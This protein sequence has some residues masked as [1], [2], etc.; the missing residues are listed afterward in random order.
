MKIKVCGM[1]YPANIAEV[2]ALRP[3]L[4]G[5]IFYAPSKRF[6]GEDFDENFL[7]VTLAPSTKRVG[8][9][10]NHPET[11]IEEKARQYSLDILQLHGDEEMAFCASL[12]Q[13]GYTLIKAFQVDS[14]FDFA[15]TKPYKEVAD[16]FLFD[17][18]SDAYGGTG[19]K[20]DWSILSTYDNEVPVV[21]SGGIE[22]DSVEE[23][24]KLSS[25]NIFALDINSR[26]ETEPGLKDPLKIEKFIA[27]IRNEVRS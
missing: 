4:L 12:K 17:T 10:V 11:Y 24:K 7:N 16:Y 25:L 15:V 18:K 22:P 26:F 23:I 20:F 3:D 8:V 5:F 2:A 6:V 19:K 21:L 1:K 27:A 13:K 9:F 14:S